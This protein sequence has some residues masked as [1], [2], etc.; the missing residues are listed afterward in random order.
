[1]E[2]PASCATVAVQYLLHAYESNLSATGTLHP[3]GNAT[4]ILYVTLYSH[5]SLH[6]ILE[7]VNDDCATFSPRPL[8]RGVMQERRGFFIWTFTGSIL[9]IA[10]FSYLMNWW[11]ATVGRIAGIPDAVRISI[12]LAQVHLELSVLLSNF[13]SSY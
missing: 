9:W 10:V 2:S 5:E 11:A 13:C 6:L 3:H 4:C 8:C 12:T 1:M 7:V